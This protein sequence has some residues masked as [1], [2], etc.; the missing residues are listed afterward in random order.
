MR[1]FKDV[2][3]DNELICIWKSKDEN[4]IVKRFDNQSI[5]IIQKE[6]DELKIEE[7]LKSSQE[8]FALEYE[9]K[10]I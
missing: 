3:K 6:F 10:W 9:M 5:E 4:E 8:K 1:Y 2:N 7:T